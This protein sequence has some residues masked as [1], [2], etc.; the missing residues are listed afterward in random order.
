MSAVGAVPSSVSSHTSVDFYFDPACPF[1]WIASRWIIEVAG[2]RD[3]DL[4]FRVMSLSVLNEG[5]TAEFFTRAWKP[6][7]VLVAAEQEHGEQAVRALY[8]AMGRRIH[9]DRN[10]N[11]D[12]V[13]TQAVAEVG[14]PAELVGV[15]YRT[16]YDEAVRESHN[17]GMKPVGTDVGTPV[18]H[19]DG[20]A[21]FGPVLNSIP[22]GEAA[23]RLFDLIYELTHTE[24]FFE[25]KR[26][27]PNGSLSFD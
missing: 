7:R 8:D 6:V 1:A 2:Q 19:I 13:I 16:D 14:L 25:L 24:N 12:E 11:Y 27:I 23:I 3:L 5:E 10:R 18:I 21:F 20:K 17:A 9:H 26:S 4:H 15:A 22:R